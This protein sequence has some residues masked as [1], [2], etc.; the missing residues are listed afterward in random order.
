VYIDPVTVTS[1]D[2]ETVSVMIQTDEAAGIGS[3]TMQLTYDPAKV[4]YD[5]K[6][7]NGPIGDVTVYEPVDGTINMVAATSA[8]PGPDGTFTFVELKFCPVGNPGECSNLG[9][10]VT[11]MTD[12]AGAVIVPDQVTG[13]EFCIPEGAVPSTEVY[14]DPATVTSCDCETIPVMIRTDKAAGIGSA[15][16]QLTYDP[17]KVEYDS[18]VANGPIGDVTVFEPVAGTINMV[19]ATS[20]DP[21]PDGTFTFVEL[22]FCPVGNPGECSNLGITVTEMTDGAGAVIVP[23]QVTGGEFCIAPLNTFY[24]DADGDGYGDPGVTQVAC[25]APTGY[26]SDHTDCNDGNPNIHPGAAEVCNGID[27]DCDGQIDEGVKNT[28]YRDADGDG[29]GNA[30]VSTE[31]CSAPTGYVSDH[32][33]CDDANAAVNPG[34]TEVYNGIDDDCDGQIDEDCCPCDFCLD[35]KE[36]WNFVSVPKRIDGTNDATTIFNLD[37]ANETCEYYNASAGSWMAPAD[38]SVVPCQGYWVWKVS[39]EMICIDFLST[40]AITPPMQQL[41]EGWN[42]IGHIDTSV[43]LIDAGTI[44]DFGSM[45]NIEGKFSQIWQWKDDKWDLCYPPGLNYMTPGQG[46]W[47]WMTEDSPMSGTP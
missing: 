28:Y 18:K 9:I 25:S 20:D 26:V 2:C 24:R 22:K 5:S 4:T 31:A 32:T 6:V 43:M 7:A 37:P 1:D 8:D 11:E 38:I 14:V 44:A 15:T 30:S 16:I 33:D 27:D 47:I 45:A 10:T 23:D 46:Y 19:A 41:C 35:L 12:G 29:Y 42:M 13:G 17:A 40:G 34:A 39:A 36:G 21:G 3:A